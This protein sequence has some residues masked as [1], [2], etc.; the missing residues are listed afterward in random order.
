MSFVVFGAE[1]VKDS[2]RQGYLKTILLL[3]FV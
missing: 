3:Q 2:I 1:R